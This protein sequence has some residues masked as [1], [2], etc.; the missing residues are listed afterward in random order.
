MYAARDKEGRPPDN[1]LPEIPPTC[2]AD[3]DTIVDD[4]EGAL[5]GGKGGVLPYIMVAGDMT[6]GRCDMYAEAG[7]GGAA[8]AAFIEEAEE[9]CGGYAALP[10]E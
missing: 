9:G 6:T 2:V 7:G 10:A 8:V 4:D 5:T 1:A 3:P